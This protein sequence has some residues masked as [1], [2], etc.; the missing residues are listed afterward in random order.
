MF[1]LVKI[2]NLCIVLKA[3]KYRL[4]P[5]DPQ[6]ELLDKHFGSVRFVFNLALETKTWAYSAHK[7]NLSRYDLQVQLKD[8]KQDCTWLREVN[9]QSLQAALLSLDMAYAHLF[10]GRGKF[11]NFKKRSGKQSFLCPQNITIENG[12]LCIPKFKK[13]IN[14]VLH[15]KIKGIIKSAILSKTP[16]G[17]YFVSILNSYSESF[18]YIS[19]AVNYF[20]EEGQDEMMAQAQ[21]VKGRLFCDWAQSGHPQ[22][23][24]SGLEAYHHALHVFKKADA[25]EIFAEIH[26]QLG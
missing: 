13:G 4:Y 15:R 14:I 26:H 16:T 6:K 3:N 24:R 2:L 7:I 20:N 1:I 10:K 25:P 18:G 21:L 11:P 23:Y 22:F 9:S 19:K 17:K 5:S 12:C 8:L